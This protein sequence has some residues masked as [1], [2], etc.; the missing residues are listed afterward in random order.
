MSQSS[1]CIFLLPKKISYY[2]V[3]NPFWELFTGGS[4][5]TEVSVTD[6]NMPF[7][8]SPREVY[9]AN[10]LNEVICQLRYP[11]ILKVS[12]ESPAQFQDAVRNTYPLYTKIGGLG[13]FASQIPPEI[14]GQIPPEIA[15]QIPPE[16]AEAFA[17]TLFPGVSGSPT[18]I[19]STEDESKSI[20]LT[21]EFIAVTER[22]YESWE[23]FRAAVKFAER[24]FREV[25]SPASYIRVGLRYVDVLMRSRFGSKDKPW[26]ELLN[27]SFIGVLG[28]DGAAP[29]VREIT[30]ESMLNI[31]D[32]ESGRVVIR[33]GLRTVEEE[34][35]QV[36]VIDADFQSDKRCDTNGAFETLEKFHQWG[37]NLFRWATKEE[38]RDS[39]GREPI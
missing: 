35:E 12:V 8:P 15:G 3:S 37:G 32:V 10:P 22:Q 19:F 38:L 5:A 11:P 6:T 39:L 31:P 4:P 14:A 20:S 24:T 29:Y 21:Q 18:H 2:S 28:D 30:I 9:E 33:H 25:Y 34:T 1:R 27:P 26:S 7:P 17:S 23:D 13:G 16:I 36:Y